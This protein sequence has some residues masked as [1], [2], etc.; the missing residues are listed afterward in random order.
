MILCC[1]GIRA[2]WCVLDTVTFCKIQWVCDRHDR[3]LME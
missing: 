3:M 1:S 2:V